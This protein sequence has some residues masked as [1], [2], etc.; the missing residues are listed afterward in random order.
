MFHV[1][2]D[3]DRGVPA[4]PIGLQAPSTEDGDGQGAD[5][6]QGA[7]AADG[8]QAEGLSNGDFQFPVL[9]SDLL[10]GSGSVFLVR[11]KISLV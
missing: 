5:G 8:V 2:G 1:T 6:D 7:A 10:V 9:I 11:F 4:P 3:E